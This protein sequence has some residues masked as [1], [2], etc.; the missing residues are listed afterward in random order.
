MCYK[1]NIMLNYKV[2][3]VSH[4]QY[5]NQLLPLLVNSLKGELPEP[6][7]ALWGWSLWLS[8]KYNTAKYRLHDLCVFYEYV[9]RHYPTFFE[10]AAKFNIIT[11]RKMNDLASFLLINFH[12]DIDDGVQVSPSTFN[13]RIDSIML[14]LQY[15]YSR[16]IEK[17][18]DPDKTDALSRTV[19]RQNAH[20]A[21]KR[22][23]KAE[24]ENQTKPT[25]PIDEEQLNIIRDIVRP[26]DDNFINEINPFRRALQRRN[27]C[28]VMLLCELG[29][30]ASE[31]VLIRNSD[32]DLKLT[33]NPTVV[34]QPLE[35]NSNEF[36][37][38]KDGA[39]HKTLGRELPISQGLASLIIEYIE[40]DRPKLRKTY[41]GTLTQYLFVS[42][43]DGGPMTTKGLAYVINNL[44]RKIPDLK[45]VVRPHQFRVTRGSELRDSI[46]KSYE[47][48]NSP[49]IKAG[50][51][52]DTLTTWGGWS[53][54]SS[55]P[56]RYTNASLQK[57]IRDYLA[58][59]EI[60]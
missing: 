46:D 56:K 48:A 42:D 8:K 36:R 47:G 2:K 11:R 34:I 59:K 55:M 18:E 60:A 41:K 44:Y 14:F 4:P 39:S 21:K 9:D 45:Q 29:C 6:S 49:M 26:S 54:T 25:K 12:Y 17:I 51:M 37:A 7:A 1:C 27:A 43:Q 13:R 3:S 20:L 16:Y 23:S 40:K 53:S 32:D 57:R 50:D 30:R 24:V 15:H 22:F 5:G 58:E 35:T 19:S 52:Q 33:T 28:L 38:R 10:D 31:L